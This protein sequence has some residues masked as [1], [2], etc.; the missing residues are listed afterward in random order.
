MKYKF[1]SAFCMA[2]ALLLVGAAFAMTWTSPK[3]FLTDD[4]YIDK[5]LPDENFG[6]E[7]ILWVTS[8]GGDPQREAWLSFL[9]P[10]MISAL[11]IKSID[12]IASAT[13]RV[14]AK[15]VES[16]GEVKLHFYNEWFPEDIMVWE[17]GLEYDPEIDG[18]VDI[19]DEGWYEIDATSLVKKAV[20]ECKDCP[21]SAVLVAKGDASVG[22]ASKED[23]EGNGP[24]LKVTLD[25]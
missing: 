11:N 3:G 16:P 13:L 5:S 1:R 4:A 17:H 7:E 9:T 15:E 19:S 22:F 14:Y 10:D 20:L 8:E 21:F 24:V 2:C 18:V 6:T 25:R 12:E 23:P